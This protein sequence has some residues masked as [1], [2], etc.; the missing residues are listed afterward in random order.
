MEVISA[1]TRKD[2]KRF[3][4]FP[5]ELY[6]GDPLWV[7]PL[8]NDER[9]AYTRCGN[10]VLNSSDYTLFLAHENGKI[11]GRTVAYVDHAFNRFYKTAIGFF[12][13]FECIDQD[14]A[15]ALIASSETWLEKKGMSA[16]RGPIHPAAENW[17]FLFEGFETPPVFMSPYNPPEYNQYIASL[18]YTKI[19][20]LLVY[21][22]DFRKG[23]IIPE[24]FLKFKENFLKRNPSFSVRRINTKRLL[25]EAEIIWE[26]SNASLSGNWGYVPVD[27]DIMIDMVKK[28]GAILDENA[29]WFV[30]DGGQAVGFCLGFPDLNVILKKIDG[31]MFPLGFF[32]ILLGAKRLTDYRLFGLAVLPEYHGLGLDVLLY[33]HLYEYLKPKCIRLEAN[34]I[35]ED[36]YKIRNAL[37]KLDLKLIKTY[38][39]YE[40]RL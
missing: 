22:G 28:L 20:D 37:E 11:L 18:G 15:R 1:E 2:I 24:R 38:R 8:W 33:V 17:G 3:A 34:Y 9:R 7:P 13:A 30:E 10:P 23:Y 6:K 32:S 27:R 36:N 39:I 14:T 4:F 35:L 31:K 5:K 19:K 12:G 16:I 40:K 25:K 26:L 29:V 21:E